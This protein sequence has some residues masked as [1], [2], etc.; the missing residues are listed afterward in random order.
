M[1]DSLC[2][3]L[4]AAWHAS[5][6]DSYALRA[7]RAICEPTDSPPYTPIG[8]GYGLWYGL[9]ARPCNRAPRAV[10][11]LRAP[12]TDTQLE[13]LVFFCQTSEDRTALTRALPARLRPASPVVRQSFR[14]AKPRVFR[15]QRIERIARKMRPEL[16]QLGLRLRPVALLP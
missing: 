5:P 3:A 15:A 12:V 4:A 8:D 11:W 14:S 1:S 7:F 9:Q 10:C 16:R 2:L 6:H 13:A